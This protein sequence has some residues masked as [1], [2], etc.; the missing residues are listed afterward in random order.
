MLAVAIASAAMLSGCPSRLGNAA[1]TV[2]IAEGEIAIQSGVVQAST[3]MD[4]DESY[5]RGKVG[6]PQAFSGDDVAVSL[7]PIDG[8]GKVGVIDVDARGF[9]YFVLATIVNVPKDDGSY[10]SHPV[11][12]D[13]RIKWVAVGR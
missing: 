7:Y 12:Y 11:F 13:G 2:T 1:P 4:E 6:F 3:R 8:P 10:D 9:N 5:V